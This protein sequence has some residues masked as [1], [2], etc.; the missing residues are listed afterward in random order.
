MASANQLKALIKSHIEGDETHFYSIA[1]QMAAHEA[2]LGHGKLAQEL[3]ALIDEA[4]KHRPIT[5]SANKPIPLAKPRGELSSLLNASYPKLRISDMVLEKGIEER[6][7]KIIKE[8]RQLVKIRSYGLSPRKK[9]LLIG[10]PGTG[11]TMSASMLAGELGLPLLVVRLE[12]LIT[13]YMGETAAKLRV[14]FNAI[15]ESRGVYLFDEFDSI[16][17]HRG[18]TNEVGEIRRILNS[19]LQMIE[20]DDSDSIILAA[21][22]HPHILDYAL[23]RR[24]DDVVEYS[25]PAKKL[26]GR[27]LRNRL[28]AFKISRLPFQKISE[29]AEGLS[30]AEIS[31]ICDDAI[32]DAIIYDRDKVTANDLLELVAE[33]KKFLNKQGL[34]S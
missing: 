12:G 34:N 3:R 16:G 10:P 32:K 18:Q 31:K 15:A 33:R 26:I 14:V 2:R 22:N 30:H 21:T 9:L 25:L 23:Y 13:K 29:E 1:M 4:K 8:Q 11:K 28:S 6:F 19:F 27:I 17:S 24:F 7:H 5:S 20:Q